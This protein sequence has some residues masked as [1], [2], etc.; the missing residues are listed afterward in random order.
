MA[1]LGKMEN[2]LRLPLVPLDEQHSDTVRS[3]LKTAGALH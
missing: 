1:L 2:V 3:A